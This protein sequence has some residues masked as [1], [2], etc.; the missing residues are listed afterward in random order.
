ME[1]ILKRLFEEWAGEGLA[2]MHA[3]AANGSNRRYWRMSGPSRRCIAAFNDDV[4]EN[5]A[6]F[7]YSTALL[8]RGVAVPELYAVS[9]DRR[10]YLQQDLGDVTLYSYLYDK[11]R[12]GEG[13]DNEALQL[14]QRVLGDLAHMQ[15]AGRDLDFSKAYPRKDFDAQSIQWDLNYF[16]YY[17]LKM[18]YIPFDEGLLEQDF[19]TLTDY[20]LGA[21]C[22]FFMYRDFQSRNIMLCEGKPYYI[23]YQGGRRGAAQYDVA[24]LLYSAKSDLPERVREELLEYYI[25]CLSSLFP[26]DREA[27]RQRYYGYVLIRI[28]QAMGAYGYRGYFERKSHFLLSVPYA[29]RNLKSILDS[30]SLPIQL[31]ELTKALHFIINSDFVKPYQPG[32]RLTVL[33]QSFSFKKS[34]P[35]DPSPN[36]GGFVFDCRALPNPGREKRFAHNTGQ[37]ACIVEY[38][39]QY[40]V[41]EEFKKHV[42]AIVDQAVDNYLERRFD[43]LMVSFGCTG[44]Q[45]RSVYFAEQTAKHIREKYPAVN[46]VLRHTEQEGN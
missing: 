34:I 4:A 28:M 12:K 29:V 8:S 21:D 16:K 32:E 33:V 35:Q 10:H 42:F 39:E 9:H 7:S 13:F 23:D 38:L 24:S 2:E 25:D 18:R 1:E 46:V 22:G 36:G 37:D 20:L 5:E 27:F 30:W 17:F 14:Y 41:V 45:H 26:L 43:H 15:V 31:P 11:K 19:H 40:P 44:G 3:L 6:F